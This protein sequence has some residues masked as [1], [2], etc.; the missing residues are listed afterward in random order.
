[1]SQ[2]DQSG[3][4]RESNLPPPFRSKDWM[5]PIHIMEHIMEDYF[6]QSINSNY[7]N[8]FWKH[9]ARHTQK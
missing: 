5:M 8:L 1:M 2:I 6:T 9:P 4:E 7:A 3:R